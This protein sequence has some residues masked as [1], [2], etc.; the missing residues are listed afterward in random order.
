MYKLSTILSDHQRTIL[1][2]TVHYQKTVILGNNIELYDGTHKGFYLAMKRMASN[3]DY[4]QAVDWMASVV[5]CGYFF[6]LGL[7]W[8]DQI[9]LRGKNGVVVI[10][11]EP[12]V[13][14]NSIYIDLME[15]EKEILAK[16]D[17]DESRNSKLWWVSHLSAFSLGALSY[18]LFQSYTR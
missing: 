12:M 4:D 6:K 17:Q 18:H 14:T 10:N 8:T 2:E 9:V 1:L 15:V 11:R 13:T 16:L 7:N 3:P 5:Q